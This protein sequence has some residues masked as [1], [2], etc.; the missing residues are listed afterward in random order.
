MFGAL[1]R[2]VTAHPWSVIAGWV[3]AAVLVIVFSPDLTTFTSNNNASFLPS[4]YQSVKAQDTAQNHFPASAGASGLIAVS[5][6]GGGVLSGAD[7]QKVSK[8]AASLAA[9]RIRSV[10]SVTT[11]SAYLSKDKTVQLVQVLF[12]GQAGDQG[13]NAAV[14]EVRDHTDSFLS[15]S[16]LKGGLTGNAAISVDSTNAFNSAE[17]VIGIATVILILL[18]LGIVFRSPIIMAL[19]IVVIAVVHQMAQGITAWIADLFGFVVGPELAPLL[20]VVMFGVG[21]DYIVFLLFRY[22]E[23]IA[24]GDQARNSLRYSVARVG[25]VVASA[26]GTVIAAFAALLVASLESL[27][28]LAPGLIVG[29]AL[30]LLAG[31]T[32]VPA[33]MSL[34]GIRLFWPAYPK[35]ADAEHRTRSERIGALVAKHP[36]IVLAICGGGLIALGFGTLGYQTT[37]NQLAELPSSTPSQQAYNTMAAAFPAGYLGPTQVFVTS[38]APLK[39]SDVK[40]LAAKL[41][42]TTGVASVLAPQYTKDQKAAMIQS[43]LKD[44][45]Y[46]ITAIDNVAGPVDTAAHGSVPGATVLV[47]GTTSQLVDVRTALRSDMEHVFPLAL[48]IVGVILGLLLRA[49]AAPVYLLIGVVITYAATLG[50]IVLVFLKGFGFEGLDFTIPIIV[51][52]FVM[53]IGTDYNIL[54]ASRL[55]EEFSVGEPARE[56]ARIAIR[57]GAPAVS[58]AGL[59]L[60]G[61]FASLLLTGIQLLEEI[62]L[63]VALG[64]LLAANILATKIVPTLAA[65]RGW[66]FWWPHKLHVRTAADKREM[67]PVEDR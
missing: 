63:A 59:I 42:K 10:T 19:P 50:A 20:L 53:A 41:A 22:R 61:T 49:V 58:A 52:L 21:T 51:Y 67:L 6:T 4:T 24:A 65:L 2:S 13:P 1:G 9:D 18:L 16:G 5:R 3:V 35:P 7:Q 23:R 48:L 46:S 44:D 8:L 32:L 56:A 14:P 34:F 36:A 28:T 55:R 15:G 17:T 57:H 66:H 45:P 54:M 33:V 37:Y 43:L 30:M 62:G 40:N 64:V 25:A 39:Q 38:Q 26:A 29:V 47:G 31:L 12:S 60:A 11:S 27:R